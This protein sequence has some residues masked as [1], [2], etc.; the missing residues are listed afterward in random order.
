MHLTPHILVVKPRPDRRLPWLLLLLAPLLLAGFWPTY[1]QHVTAARL[2]LHL[3]GLTMTLWVALL[4][5]QARFASIGRLRLHR[6]L[7]KAGWLFGPLMLGSAAWVCWEMASAPTPLGG[8]LRD[9][10]LPVGAWLIA[11]TS[12]TI[13]MT[14]THRTWLH[15]RM[16]LVTALA[17]MGAGIDRV[18]L[19]Y[20][21]GLNDPL[22]AGHANF[23]VAELVCLALV[24]LDRRRNQRIGP[25]LG[26]FA[27]FALNHVWLANHSNWAWYRDVVAAIQP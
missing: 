25:F 4:I 9:L 14:Q 11:T 7:G 18:F 15:K 5:A 27:A 1:L 22:A 8:R 24:A 16:M 3:H 26:A 10:V 13:A 2:S 17:L 20:V 6:L 12:W 19:F 21:P 23:V